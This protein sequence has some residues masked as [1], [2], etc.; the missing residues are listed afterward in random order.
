M[1]RVKNQRRKLI[2]GRI[3]IELTLETGEKLLIRP[4]RV[5]NFNKSPETEIDSDLYQQLEEENWRNQLY[6]R[7]Q[8]F[9]KIRP[10]SVQETRLYLQQAKFG[11]PNEKREKII[12]ELLQELQKEGQ[13]DDQSFA[14]WWIQQ[15]RQ[16]LRP[17]GPR[18]I[19]AELRQKGIDPTL[20]TSL[21]D[22]LSPEEDLILARQLLE[23]FK[24][25]QKANSRW[26]QKAA[27]YLKRRGFSYEVI[28]KIVALQSQKG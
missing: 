10:R 22:A 2:H 27:A 28:R 15:R 8:R 13:L 12:T 3:F 19:Y 18:A 17:K 6:F 20:A 9:L 26:Q 7:L 14:R 1:P 23:K 11:P 16:G 4:Q 5:K 21:I 25:R 24:K